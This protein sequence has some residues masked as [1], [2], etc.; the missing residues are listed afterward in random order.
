MNSKSFPVLVL[1]VDQVVSTSNL[2]RFSHLNFP[3]KYDWQTFG[4]QL[5]LRL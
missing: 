3:E 2:N 4:M 5:K 1:C